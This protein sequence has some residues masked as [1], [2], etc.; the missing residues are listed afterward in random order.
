[1]EKNDVEHIVEDNHERYAEDYYGE[2]NFNSYRNKIGALVLIKS[3]TNKSI[4]DKPFIEKKYF[5]ISSN[6]FA[7]S[8]CELPY[9]HEMGF[10][11]FINQHNF[12]FKPY[13]K[14]GIQEIDERTELVAKIA[15]YIWNRDRIIEIE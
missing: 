7:S 1:M 15:D 6:F 9:V 5:Y 11:D 4:Q 12:D 10:K 2:D 8:L 3:G 14:F 13:H